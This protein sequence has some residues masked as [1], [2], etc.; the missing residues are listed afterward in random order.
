MAPFGPAPAIVGKEMS[1]S[2]PVSRRKL[3]SAATTSISVSLPPGG[4]SLS[5]QARKRVTAAPSR[6][7][8]LR[9]PTISAWFL[10]AFNSVIGSGPRRACLINAN[11]LALEFLE[12]AGELVRRANVGKGL[13]R[14]PHGVVE[15]GA[16]HIKRGPSV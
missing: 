7:W 16:V 11:G 13:D 2:A 1:L 15:L 14:V 3:S 8:A 6:R 10:I 12:V 4:A 5:S 9:L